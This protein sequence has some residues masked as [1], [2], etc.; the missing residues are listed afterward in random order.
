MIN[1]EVETKLA[2]KEA[3]ERLKDFF[4]KKGLGLDLTEDCDS[5][6]TFAGGGGYVKAE[7][8]TEKGK[9]RVQLTGQEWDYQIKEFS[10]GLK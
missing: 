1:L 5:Y 10:K 7:V 4:G 3:I 2:P 8:C 6:L 9:T